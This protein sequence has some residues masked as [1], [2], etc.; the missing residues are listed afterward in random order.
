MIKSILFWFQL[1]HKELY[2]S[3]LGLYLLIVVHMFSHVVCANDLLSMTGP[4]YRLCGPDLSLGLQ[5][6]CG[7]RYAD[8]KKKWDTDELEK[9]L[10]I[11]KYIYNKRQ[12]SI[13]IV[14]MCCSNPF[15]CSIEALSSFCADDSVYR[16]AFLR[17]VGHLQIAVADRPLEVTAEPT[18]TDSVTVPPSRPNIGRIRPFHPRRNHGR[19]H[20][21]WPSISATRRPHKFQNTLHHV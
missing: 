6:L 1:H 10:R 20:S 7:S 18:A 16:D 19:S 14:E 13:G 11:K 3:I 17:T 9:P 15:G 5:S 4:Y 21:I 12:N 8:R 2:N